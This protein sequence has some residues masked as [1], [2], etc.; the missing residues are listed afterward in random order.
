MD[1]GRVEGRGSMLAGEIFLD[2][3]AE[4][5]QSTLKKIHTFVPESTFADDKEVG[6]YGRGVVATAIVED[7]RKPDQFYTLAGQHGKTKSWAV[8]RIDM[9]SFDRDSTVKVEKIAEVPGR[10]G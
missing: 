3:N 4:N 7:P 1:D 5:P 2:P 8:F 10:C 9:A 6:D